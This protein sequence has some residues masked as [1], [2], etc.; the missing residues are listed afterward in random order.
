MTAARPPAIAP[1]S[2]PRAGAT[3][4]F[5]LVAGASPV[6]AGNASEA[7]GDQRR[8]PSTDSTAIVDGGTRRTPDA[9]NGLVST[10]VQV[11]PL[12]RVAYSASGTA[13]ARPRPS[14]ASAT[15]A[16][17]VL[18]GPTSR[19]VAPASALCTSAPSRRRTPTMVWAAALV[20]ASG[21]SGEL[22]RTNGPTG[23]RAS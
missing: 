17:R 20:R 19:Q 13:T 12:S 4:S 8:V 11:A 2:G 10:R 23:S 7:P 3:G 9:P 16:K 18:P 21:S 5:Q 22:A 15:S 6:S 1:A 14:L